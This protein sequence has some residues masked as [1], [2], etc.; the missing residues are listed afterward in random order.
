MREGRWVATIGMA[1]AMVTGCT[2]AS[3][4]V[5][6]VS[7]AL[8]TPSPADAA[9]PHRPAQL[10]SP[11]DG[12]CSTGLSN[13]PE[14]ADTR[15]TSDGDG[16]ALSPVSGM[17][18]VSAGGSVWTHVCPA[19]PQA[20][21]SSEFY[22]EGPDK[23]WVSF[24][25]DG[26]WWV[27]R[28]TDRG[29]TW[30]RSLVSDG[31]IFGEVTDA[32]EFT[33][34]VDF[35]DTHSGRLV[36]SPAEGESAMF[37]T[38][39]GGITWQLITSSGPTPPKAFAPSG[40]QLTFLDEEQGW[41]VFPTR[42]SVAE[43]GMTSTAPFMYRTVD[44]GFTW[45]AEAVQVV[46]PRYEADGQVHGNWCENDVTKPVFFD[47]LHGYFEYHLQLV[48][49]GCPVQYLTVLV[50]TVDGGVTWL[51][52]RTLVGTGWDWLDFYSGFGLVTCGRSAQ[53]Q[54]GQ[55][56]FSHTVN[57]VPQCIGPLPPL[58]GSLDFVNRSDG[59]IAR[60]NELL[61]TTDGG[62]TWIE[63]PVTAEPGS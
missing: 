14:L 23:A 63:I 18:N 3:I 57:V 24:H 2:P 48:E 36:I 34:A 5:Q 60:G 1:L 25:A 31:A 61:R 50:R 45:N 28:T 33:S 62:V 9:D 53:A 29:A 49:A 59:W 8:H 27:A 32:R 15:L 41:L 4:A 44:G 21:R 16:W 52:G 43:S 11:V 58:S 35:V 40:P 54:A 7:P 22:S 17:W 26:G 47:R 12:P 20:I 42:I 46:A 51:P 38:R 37:G 56:A 39:D 30:D 10:W 13:A 19:G 6:P 55:L